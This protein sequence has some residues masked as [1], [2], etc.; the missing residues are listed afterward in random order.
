MTPGRLMVRIALPLVFS[1]QMASGETWEQDLANAFSGRLSEIDLE[2]EKVEAVLPDLPSLPVDDQGGTGGFA[3]LY[4]EPVGEFPISLMWEGSEAVDF[5][6]LVPPRR[7]GVEGL[8]SQY[9]TPD[10]FRVELLGPDGEVVSTVAEVDRVWAHPVRD[11]HPFVFPLPSPVEA[12]GMRVVATRLPI[13]GEKFVHAWAEWFVYAGDRNLAPS[14]TEVIPSE[15]D[16]VLTPSAPWHWNREFLADGQTPLGLPELPA[17]EHRNIGWLSNGRDRADK[18]AWLELDLGESKSFDALRLIPAKRPTSDLPS[19]FGFPRELRVSVS[20]ERSGSG[21]GAPAGD[22]VVLSMRNP[23]HNPV[24]V[25]L[26]EQTGRYVRIEATQLWKPFDS[27]PAF[28]ALSE[29][30]VLSGPENLAL[31]AAVRS[32][33]GMGNVIASGA[34]FWSTVSLCDGF[35]PDGKLVSPRDWLVELDRRLALETE[36]HELREEAGAIVNHWRRMGLTAFGLIGLAG[37]F[38]LIVLPLRYRV[39][40]RKELK[41][42]R[43]RIAGDLHD[44]VGSNL[45]SIQ[46]FADLAEGRIGPTKELK[47]I[48]RIAAETV[49]AVR[50][51]VWLLR[52]QGG[53]RIGTVEHMRETASIMLEPVEWKFTANEPAWQCELEDEA[54]RHL[55]LFFREALHNILRHAEASVVTMRAEETDGR[56]ILKIRDDGKGIPPEKMARPSTLRAL[57]QR[58]EALGA[59]L[60]VDT[61]PGKGTGLVLSIP[62]EKRRR[63]SPTPGIAQPAAAGS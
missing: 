46:M 16:N 51:I 31:G 43:E 2:I 12:S 60:E 21:S 33:D 49:S 8:E 22:A 1:A 9:G 30:E 59:K 7:Y 55:F 37:A 32:P 28:F 25:P 40:A 29:V 26:G 27:F 41:K 17:G 45:G 3:T 23:G 13:D 35:G 4:P 19:G 15:K 36:R 53:H 5:V 50:D 10:A 18:A 44:E 14:A 48:Q 62:L 24:A 47:R 58:T 52:P 56:F 39:R 54:S 61:E 34:R 11:G 6:A 63:K 57:H 20:E 42:V 38:A